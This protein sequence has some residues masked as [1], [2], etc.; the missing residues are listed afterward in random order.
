MNYLS[1]KGQ[2]EIK[3]NPSSEWD[4]KLSEFSSVIQRVEE[5]E[6]DLLQL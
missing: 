4:I 2:T 6:N 5:N 3:K 1:S